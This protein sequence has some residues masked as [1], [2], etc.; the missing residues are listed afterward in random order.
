MS[1]FCFLSLYTFVNRCDGCG[2]LFA[3]PNWEVSI[4]PEIYVSNQ[5][6]YYAIIWCIAVMCCAVHSYCV[7]VRWRMQRIY[8]GTVVVICILLRASGVCWGV[9]I[10]G[11][12]PASVLDERYGFFIFEHSSQRSGHLSLL[13]AL[14]VTISQSVSPAFFHV[15]TCLRVLIMPNSK[16]VTLKRSQKK[17]RKRITLGPA[18]KPSQTH[19]SHSPGP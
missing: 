7:L 3:P 12:E 1:C 9:F 15:I 18:K 11:L 4:H 10:A 14:A 19:E 2:T 5:A 8:C 17:I 13:P 16:L 6:P